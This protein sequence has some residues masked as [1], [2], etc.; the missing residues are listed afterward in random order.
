V[1]RVIMTI[2]GTVAGLAM[3]LGFKTQPLGTSVASSIVPNG[4][5]G[6]TATG[7][8]NNSGSSSGTANNGGSS[9]NSG[10]STATTSAKQTVTGQT[11]NTPYGP[12]QIRVTSSNGQITNVDVLQAPWGNPQDQQI[13]SYALPILVQE[14]LKAQTA[15]IDMVSGATYTSN[16]YVMSLQSALDQLHA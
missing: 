6:A 11:A 15:S 9:G 2:I 1:K 5:S 7:Q 14:T 4:G 12:V 3:L 10:G 16:G 8:S 13:N